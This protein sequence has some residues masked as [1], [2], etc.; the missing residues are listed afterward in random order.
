MASRGADFWNNLKVSQNND[1]SVRFMIN[2]VVVDPADVAKEI[3][4]E[5]VTDMQALRYRLFKDK[6]GQANLLSVKT[7]SDTKTTL[8]GLD[9][10]V[11]GHTFRN[12][13]TIS[14][15]AIDLNTTAHEIGHSLGLEHSS[16]GLMTPSSNDLFRSMSISEKQIEEIIKNSKTTP[17]D[18]ALGVGHYIVTK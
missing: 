15:E 14:D 17:I 16:K 4:K 9:A 10:I 2:V 7:I 3:N 1:M 6:S 12:Q 11:Q 13:I 5:H 8:D 18:K